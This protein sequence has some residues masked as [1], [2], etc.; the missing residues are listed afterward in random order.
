MICFRDILTHIQT[1]DKHDLRFPEV[2][3]YGPGGPYFSLSYTKG[4][5]ST[6][7]GTADDWVPCILKYDEVHFY[8]QFVRRGPYW[9]F[10]IKVNGSLEMASQWMF[11]A[12][13][14]NKETGIRMEFSGSVSPVDQSV[15]QVIRNG[16]DFLQI[17]RTT[18]EK[19]PRIIEIVFEVFKNPYPNSFF[20]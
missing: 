15:E 8:P 2:L 17:N 10:W 1:V 6:A 5:Y 18:I 3:Y 19:L 14:Q 9:Y 4:L 12:K 20:P 13:I 7:P 11:S 16:D